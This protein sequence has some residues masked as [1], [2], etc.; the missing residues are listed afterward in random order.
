VNVVL[1]IVGTLF[2]AGGVFG[3]YLAFRTA[4]RRSDDSR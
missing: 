1:A 2:I 3:L 4:Q